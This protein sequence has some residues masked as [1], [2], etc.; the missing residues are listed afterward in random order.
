MITDGQRSPDRFVTTLILK[1]LQDF[2]HAAADKRETHKRGGDVQFVPGMIRWGGAIAFI[3]LGEM[4]PKL[5]RHT[6][7]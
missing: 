5:A 1:A 6:N 3:M 2:L 4:G 7:L